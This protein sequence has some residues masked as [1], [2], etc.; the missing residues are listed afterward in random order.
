MCKKPFGVAK[1]LF[2]AAPCATR[3]TKLIHALALAI[4][5]WLLLLASTASM[6]D[7][8]E[9]W[10]TPDNLATFEFM[11]PPLTTAERESIRIME[12]EEADPQ[13]QIAAYESAEPIREWNFHD[14][15]NA[16]NGPLQ[17]EIYQ[18]A[19]SIGKQFLLVR[20]NAALRY[21]FAVTTG[22]TKSPTPKGKFIVTHQRWR[23]MSTLYPDSK[24][25]NMDHVSYFAPAI[26]F[27][28]T[29]LA[30]YRRLGKRGSHGCIR[31]GRPQA[32]AVFSLIKRAS[33]AEV[34]SFGDHT[35]PSAE[36]PIIKKMLA[37]DL[38]FIQSMISS[39]NKGDVP[40]STW[41]EYD[42]FSRG[43][44]TIGENE[45]RHLLKSWRIPKILEVPDHHDLAAGPS[46]MISQL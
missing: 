31:L 14:A 13:S 34:S 18:N 9:P 38:N 16:S 30:S 21:V 33:F 41:D 2:F 3:L 8:P 29:V 7:M 43:E 39:K 28:S 20:Q 46:R 27:H 10:A 22:S 25:N 5:T 1:E 40:F 26:G 44:L 36:I 4:P 35:P 15:E 32:R 37:K 24:E 42:L 19:K 12:A 23:H 45:F 11:A 17:I 6:A